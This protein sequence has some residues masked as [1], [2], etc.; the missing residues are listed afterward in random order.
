MIRNIVNK[1]LTIIENSLTAN[2]S[3]ATYICIIKRS[4]SEF[5][6]LERLTSDD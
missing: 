1:P 2:W 5:Y 4:H 6:Y 3:N